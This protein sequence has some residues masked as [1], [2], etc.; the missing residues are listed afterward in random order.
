MT[1]ADVSVVI[2]TFNEAGS[3]ARCIESARAAGATQIIV[4]DGGST[5][6]TVDV[7][8]EAGASE[9]VQSDLGRGIQL[10]RGAAE[11]S[12]EVILFLHADNWIGPHCLSQLCQQSTT[13]WGA[14]RQRIESSRRI[15]R[16]IEAGN[17]M[18]VRLLGMPFGDQAVYVRRDLFQAQ[19][20]FN[21]VPLM[22]DFE[23]SQRMRRLAKPVLLDGPVRISAR[24]WQQNGVL[25]QTLRNW[26]IQVAYR[27]GVSPESLAELYRRQR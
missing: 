3:I 19:N 26:T 22:E 21:E 9:I 25:R 18:R 20:G 5:D 13:T 2:P 6:S 12:G 11:A 16:S 17:A 24:R 10:N 14:Y 27:F 7:A 8:K 4:A 23:F 1:P 15:Y